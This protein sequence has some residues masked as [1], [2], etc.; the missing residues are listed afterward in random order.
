MKSGDG[1]TYNE[2]LTIKAQLPV[3]R[4]NINSEDDYRDM[5]VDMPQWFWF[6]IV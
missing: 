6:S 1:K 2:L 3:C 5:I 4:N